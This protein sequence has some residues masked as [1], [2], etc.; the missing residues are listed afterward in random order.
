M[1]DYN[2]AKFHPSYICSSEVTLGGSKDNGIVMTLAKEVEDLFYLLALAESVNNNKI[3][4][5][6][7]SCNKSEWRAKITFDVFVAL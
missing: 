4:L 1:M 6:T 3:K 7:S 5:L 2:R